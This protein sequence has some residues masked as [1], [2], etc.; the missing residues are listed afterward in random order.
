MNREN[1]L[2]SSWWLE[3]FVVH[4][5]YVESMF[6][7]GTRWLKSRIWPVVASGLKTLGESDVAEAGRRIPDCRLTINRKSEIEEWLQHRRSSSTGEVVSDYAEI[8][9]ALEGQ[10]RAERAFQGEC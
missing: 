3:P 1:F 7:G 5:C 8:L 9:Q 4:R 10:K 6:N 2:H